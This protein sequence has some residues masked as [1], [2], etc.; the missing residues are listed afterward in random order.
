MG[1]QGTT[2]IDF[3]SFPGGFDASVSVTGQASIL[4][5]SLVEAWIVPTATA[6]HTA[7]EHLVERIR[8]VAGNVAVGTGFT[9]Y[10]YAPDNP[11]GVGYVD[12]RTGSKAD[13]LKLYGLWTVGWV[14]N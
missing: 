12:P 8:V 6:D 4:S 5:D 9:I 13:S 14:W 10:A 1:A 2:T 7:D 11:A 3:G